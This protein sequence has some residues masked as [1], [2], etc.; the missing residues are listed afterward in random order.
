MRTP[1][2]RAEGLAKV[3]DLP[4]QQ[5][6]GRRQRLQ[7]VTDVDLEVHH[8]ET[9]ALVGESGSGKSTLG[10][11]LLGLIEPTTGEVYYRGQQVSG[12]RGAADRKLRRQVQM[13]FQS[14]YSSLNPRSTVRSIL[15]QPF[16][17]HAACPR[18]EVDERV[19][20]LLDSVGLQPATMFLDRYPHE[21]SG[22]QRQRVGIARAISLGP[23]FIVADEPLSALD[24]SVQAQILRL[25]VRLRGELDLAYLM[26]THDLLIARSLC[27][28]VYV[29][30]LGR[31][32]EQGKSEDIFTAAR[33]PYT[34]SLLNATPV[35]DPTRARKRDRIRLHGEMPSPSDPPAGCPFHTRCPFVRPERCLD[36]RP[37]LR[38]VGGGHLAACHYADE[39]SAGTHTAGQAELGGSR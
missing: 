16:L 6:F 32:V 9:V 29:L 12:L 13:I 15:R 23:E 27:D 33:H 26:I 14:P 1:V 17:V 34:L 18:R 4:A 30:Y 5:L 10:R 38:P 2:I 35:P 7:A 28:R 36:E 37:L 20:A 24:M 31:V 19:V 3:F 22:G 11:L 21:L 8:G 39:I 25:L